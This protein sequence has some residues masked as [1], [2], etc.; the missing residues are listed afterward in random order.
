MSLYYLQISNQLSYYYIVFISKYDNSLC[1]WKLYSINSDYK[2]TSLSFSWR[3][4]VT[5]LLYNEEMNL[6]TVLKPSM[7]GFKST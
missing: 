3:K 7:I 6:E 1:F 2:L 4:F 5:S